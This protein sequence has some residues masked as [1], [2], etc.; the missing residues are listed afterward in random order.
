[1]AKATLPT[2]PTQ[3][4]LRVPN[5]EAHQHYKDRNP[6]W[7]KLYNT[8]LEDYD[9]ATL[10]D[11]SKGHLILIWLYAS[12]TK[13]EIPSD[14]G[15]LKFKL[16]LH[17]MPDLKGLVEA[18][19]LEFTEE[20][21]AIY[22]DDASMMLAQNANSGAPTIGAG[23]Q[24]ML[25]SCKHDASTMLAQ[26]ERESRERAEQREN[27]CPISAPKKTKGNTL[28]GFDACW[29]VYPKKVSKGQA[30]KTWSKLKPD[31]ELYRKIHAAIL[32]QRELP[33]WKE[34]KQFIPHFSTW[35]NAERWEDEVSAE[36]TM[37]EAEQRTQ[38]YVA[39]IERDQKERNNG[40]K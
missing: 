17:E 37:T 39:A 1:M 2:K 24:P 14:P 19:F 35:L 26:R 40:T 8:L 12:R 10:P 15:F 6:P 9:F 22:S 34:D 38:R 7:I 13:N 30:K 16:G 11:L 29:E 23:S 27:S 25:A 33:K 32:V 21:L 5:W 4:K 31:E 18:G 20:T 3:P 36:E 28:R